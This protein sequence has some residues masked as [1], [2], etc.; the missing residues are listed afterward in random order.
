M[1]R[2]ARDARDGQSTRDVRDVLPRLSDRSDA[3]A[4]RVN[5][6]FDAV[7]A[8]HSLLPPHNQHPQQQLQDLQQLHPLQPPLSASASFQSS[9]RHY[10]QQYQQHQDDRLHLYQPQY[11]PAASNSDSQDTTSSTDTT[12]STDTDRLFTPPISEGGLSGVGGGSGS[13]NS[14]SNSVGNSYGF[15]HDF[16]GQDSQLLQLSELAAA[17]ARMADLNAL[18]APDT[19]ALSRKRTADGGVKPMRKTSNASPIFTGGH[20]RSTS[21]VGVASTAGGRIGELSAE[22]KAKLSYAM[23]KVNNGWQAHSI[24]QV[25]N[26]ASQATSP[27]SS[28][29]TIHGR[30]GSSASP[31]LAGMPSHKRR[32]SQASQMSQ[33]SG[34]T[35][36]LAGRTP[37]A[38][39]TSGWLPQS[40]GRYY[41]NSPALLASPLAVSRSNDSGVPR[42]LAPPVSIQPARP[43]LAARR[44]SNPGFGL[45]ALAS[46]SHYASPPSPGYMSPVKRTP[47][48]DPILFSPHQNVR[49]QDAIETLLFMSSPGNSANMKQFPSMSSQP[50]PNG[51]HESHP[52]HHQLPPMSSP[53]RHALPSAP[54]KSLPTSRPMGHRHSQSLSSRRGHNRSPSDMDIDEPFGTPQSSISSTVRG[55]P[56]RRD[57][58]HPMTDVPTPRL[59]IPLSMPSGLSGTAKPRPVLGEDDIEKMLDRAAAASADDSSDSGSEILIPVRR[60]G[61]VGM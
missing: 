24:D 41:N 49:E 45:A 10:F 7:D 26:F 2:I 59:K 8:A 25:E 16:S 44:N 30:H 22:L 14:N 42:S 56:R 27:A 46:F 17:S 53:Q 23:V 13:V 5:R 19:S 54:R 36:G 35:A 40:S 11:N 61:Q 6:A 57:N 60:A 3:T 29:S 48:M 33:I 34:S 15:E 58:G 38:I 12:A 50:L 32:L 28:T 37:A 31:R 43:S 1:N 52:L 4:S 55:T 20:S 47:N 39:D 51:H 9:S 18:D 21:T